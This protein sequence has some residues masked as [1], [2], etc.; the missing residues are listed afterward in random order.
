MASLDTFLSLSLSFLHIQVLLSVVTAVE[1]SSRFIV[2]AVQ[3]E[4]VQ[5]IEC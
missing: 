3:S 5:C 4:T 2:A 1:Q